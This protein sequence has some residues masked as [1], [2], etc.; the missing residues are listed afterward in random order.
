MKNNL[1]VLTNDKELRITS[2]EL[3]DIINEFRKLES[4]NTGRKYN[5]LRH[6]NFKTKINREIGVLESLGLKAHLNFKESSYVNSQNKNQPCYSLN[7]DGMLQILNSESA[8]VRYKTIE[9]INNLEEEN[10]KLKERQ[11]LISANKEIREL[12]GTLEDF[13]KITEEAKEMYKPSHKRKLQYDKLIKSVTSDKEEY[14]IVKEWI[15]AT[16]EIDKWE[17]TSIEQNKKILEIINTVS[18]MLNIKKFEQM[19]LL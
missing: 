15:F 4:E 3:V 12:K 8:L 17:D 1:L 5:E 10:N 7:R 11:Q 9:Y 19:S 13:K 18:R 14:D 6:D 16:L 2:V